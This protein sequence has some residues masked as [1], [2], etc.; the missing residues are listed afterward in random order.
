MNKLLICLIIVLGIN[1]PIFSQEPAE[2]QRTIRKIESAAASIPETKEGQFLITG[3]LIC[4][5][6]DLKKQKDAGAQCSLYGCSYSMKTKDVKDHK[7]T[8][9]KKYAGKFFHILANDNSAEL[10]QKEH[11]KKDIVVVG[12]LYPEENVIEVEFVKFA[13]NGNR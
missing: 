2:Q 7:G 10:L 4:T 11:K 8:P 12:R 6:C 5:S 1:T 3:T 13:G 9:V